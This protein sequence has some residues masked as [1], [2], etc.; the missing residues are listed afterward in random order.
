MDEKSFHKWA[1]QQSQSLSEVLEKLRHNEPQLSTD[2]QSHL[3]AI[4]S[5]SSPRRT[6]ELAEWCFKMSGF[7]M[8]R[9]D[10]RG[11]MRSGK[12]EKHPDNPQSSGF[13]PS[14]ATKLTR[15]WRRTQSCCRSRWTDGFFFFSL[16]FSVR[17]L[18]I[19]FS[20]KS[21]DFAQGWCNDFLKLV[22]I[23]Q[24][25]DTQWQHGSETQEV[26]LEW[27][28]RRRTWLVNDCGDCSL[29]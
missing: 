2:A 5:V 14:W 11:E 20:W 28:A 22:V 7:R 18:L 4:F 6:D 21:S 13:R 25:G 17:Y 15:N 19:C 10:E 29:V 16:I 9:L 1:A 27:T 24:C 3:S 12:S 8:S 26:Q 23:R